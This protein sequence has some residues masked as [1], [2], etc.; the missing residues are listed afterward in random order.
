MNLILRYST[1]LIRYD[2]NRDVWL[3]CTTP[4]GLPYFGKK[5]NWIKL[6]TKVVAKLLSVNNLEFDS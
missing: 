6:Y 5:I 1:Y 2:L 4:C 3:L